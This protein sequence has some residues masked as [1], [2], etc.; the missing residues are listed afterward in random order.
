MYW[1][2]VACACWYLLLQQ[3]FRLT[4][5]DRAKFSIVGSVLSVALIG[6]SVCNLQSAACFVSGTY[7]KAFY[8]LIVPILLVIIVGIGVRLTIT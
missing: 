3:W 1:T 4:D 5:Y 8:F 6:C 7:K 2:A